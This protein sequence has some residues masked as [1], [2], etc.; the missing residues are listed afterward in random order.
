MESQVPKYFNPTHVLMF[1]FGHGGEPW[2]HLPR[3]IARANK[4]PWFQFG[5]GG[6]P[7]SHTERGE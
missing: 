7:W 4:P 5:H 2:S 3:G 6:E 1:Q